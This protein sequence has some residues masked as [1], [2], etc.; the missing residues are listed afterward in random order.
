[1][2]IHHNMSSFYTVD[3]ET[4]LWSSSLQIAIDGMIFKQTN[5]DTKTKHL[6][7]S[8][9]LKMDCGVS[10]FIF[11]KLSYNHYENSSCLMDN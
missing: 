4:R 3:V 2:L 5:E 11:I 10:D 9:K 1:M 7:L 6:F 8:E